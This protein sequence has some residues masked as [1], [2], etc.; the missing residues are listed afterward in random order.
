MKFIE[1]IKPLEIILIISVLYS[2]I[3]GVGLFGFGTDYHTSY[4]KSNYSYAKWYRD[5]LGWRISTFTIFNYHLGVYLTSFI[6]AF[7]TGK[8]IFFFF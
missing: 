2:I 3:M 4:Y 8:L 1:K 7:S 6:L 5:L